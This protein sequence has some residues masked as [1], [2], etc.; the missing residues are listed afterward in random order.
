MPKVTRRFAG[1]TTIATTASD[2]AVYLDSN[3]DINKT[4]VVF[5]ASTDSNI[6]YNEA[7]VVSAK[8]YVDTGVLYVKFERASSGVY[9]NVYIDYTVIQLENTTVQRGQTVFTASDTSKTATI[10]SVDTTKSFILAT[11][12][13][14][15]T[16]ANAEHF[17]FTADL[18]NATTLTFQRGTASGT[19][20][21][22]W[23]VVTIT[24]IKSLQVKTGSVTSS[25]SNQTDVTIT[26]VDTTKSIVIPYYRTTTST[27]Q[28]KHF[29]ETHLTSATNVRFESYSNIATG[30]IYYS[31]T[32]VEFNTGKVN[33]GYS[34]FNSANTSET[35]NIGATID[36]GVALAKLQGIGHHWGEANA[37]TNN[38]GDNL[39]RISSLSTTQL[40]ASRGRSGV[41]GYFAWEII[42]FAGASG[43]LYWEHYRKQFIRS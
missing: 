11:G 5:T 42:E 32:V 13:I 40:T 31:F 7:G 26:S 43:Q 34:A 39:M 17:C 36:T 41:S 25:G 38:T 2:S 8:L 1:N 6:S 15:V 19:L 20:T 9:I 35:V 37:A 28:S 4:F 18:T 30:T 23:Q 3:W 10:T 24:D 12:R 14:N 21:V 29:R 22:E 33:R 27:F 16:S